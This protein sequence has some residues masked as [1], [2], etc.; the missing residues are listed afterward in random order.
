[1]VRVR[2]RGLPPTADEL[3]FIDRERIKEVGATGEAIEALKL[4]RLVDQ[5]YS[6]PLGFVR[7]C[8]PWGEP[9]TALE[10]FPGP[11]EWQ[12]QELREIGRRCKSA[13]LMA[14][15]RCLLSVGQWHRAMVSARAP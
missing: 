5:F 6:D 13:P 15:L 14:I 7:T 4:L 8:F 11:D 1:M 12:C 3:Q 2:V 9:G 10:H